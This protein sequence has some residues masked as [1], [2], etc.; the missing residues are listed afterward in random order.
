MCLL[1]SW[2]SFAKMDNKTALIL[3]MI[4]WP[5]MMVLPLFQVNVVKIEQKTLTIESFFEQKMFHAGEIRE[6]KMRT[7]Y[8]LY[9]GAANYVNILPIKG[10]NYS[11]AGFS[12]SGEIMY[13]VLTNW[14]IAHRGA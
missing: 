14:W 4:I 7:T 6:I 11:L 5:V 3:S 13:G 9:G 1:V 12:E 10:R 8:E 2:L